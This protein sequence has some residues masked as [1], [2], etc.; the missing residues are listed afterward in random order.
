MQEVTVADGAAFDLSADI[1]TKDIAGKTA[2]MYGYNGMIPGQLL[3]VK[4]GSAITVNFKNNLDQ[5][6]T[7]HWHGIRV[8][9]KNDGVPDITQAAVKPG[10][11]FAYELAFPDDGVYWYHPH[12]REDMQQELGLYGAII[13]EPADAKHYNAI[14]REEVL[15]L[16]DIRLAD[17]VPEG[18]SAEGAQYAMMGRFGNQMLVN[19]MAEYALALETG[20]SVR[21]FMVNTANVRPFNVSVVGLPWKVVGGDSGLYE[22]EFRADAV[23]LHPSERTIVEAIFNEPGTYRLV[24]KNPSRTYALGMITVTGDKQSG[25]QLALH[26]N[27]AVMQDVARLKT[28]AG[29]APD[30]T[31]SVLSEMQMM[32]GGGMMSGGEPVEWEDAMPMMNAHATSKNT[33]WILRDAATGKENEDIHY[34]AKVGDVKK[35]RFVNSR[36]SMH[37]MQHPMHLHGQ[38][39]LV[40]AQDGVESKNLVWKDTV[41]VPAGST[42]DILVEFTNP[43]EWMLHCH[44]PEHLESGMMTTIT[45]AP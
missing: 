33:R 7:I 40:V 11:T 22:Q 37:P 38:R 4:Q 27:P 9:N 14:D 21:F 29:R 36:S 15:F 44:I 13:V 41:A 43:G 17:G 28:E 31:L 19:G 8:A 25:K 3:R 5:P 34:A 23:V 24:H 20:Q 30:W 12:L 42:V 45:V 39:F 2:Q 16:D 18:F 32:H 26:A 6:T 35:I 1:V 10:E